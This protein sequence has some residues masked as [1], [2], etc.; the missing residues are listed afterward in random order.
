MPGK[1][2]KTQE[3]KPGVYKENTLDNMPNKK[4]RAKL[5]EAMKT[6]GDERRCTGRSFVRD[7]QDQK[8][9][10]PDGEFLRKP[11]GNNAIKGATVCNFHGGKAPQVRRAAQRRLVQMVEPAINRLDVL[12]HQN[13]HLPTALGAVATVL[14]HTIGDGKTSG[15][16]GSGAPV[17][18]IGVVFGGMA[19]APTVKQLDTDVVDAVVTEDE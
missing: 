16:G 3:R 11:C 9:K 2:A 15:G 19:Q 1:L 17:I 4:W 13:A 7:D 12:M 6:Q 5:K 8:I 18:K 14:K 10:G